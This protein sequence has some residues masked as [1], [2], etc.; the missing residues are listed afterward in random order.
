MNYPKNAVK[1]DIIEMLGLT[2]LYKNKGLSDEKKA[3]LVKEFT[4]L[5][6]KISKFNFLNADQL[7]DV[8]KEALVEAFADKIERVRSEIYAAAV[9][10][11]AQNGSIA[12]TNAMTGGQL[13]NSPVDKLLLANDTTMRK[14]Y[15]L[16]LETAEELANEIAGF[17]YADY[18]D[19]ANEVLGIKIEE[20]EEKEEVDPI[21]ALLKLLELLNEKGKEEQETSK[22]LPEKKQKTSFADYAKD[23]I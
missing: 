18:I 10:N 12:I 22:P 15:K 21:M 4:E 23:F 7:K 16:V 6:V 1:E 14:A 3:E 13:K 19:V 11:A 20:K 8:Q 5:N 9:L 17:L 2:D